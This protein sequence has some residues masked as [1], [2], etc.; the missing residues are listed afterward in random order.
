MTRRAT[1]EP[2]AEVVEADDGRAT[3]A[4]RRAATAVRTAAQALNEAVEKANDIGLT[5][6]I[7]PALGAELPAVLI[8]IIRRL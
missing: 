2:A 4:D 1:E 3:V 8:E 6:S 7:V 5:V